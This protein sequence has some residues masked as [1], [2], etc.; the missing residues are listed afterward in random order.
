M[1]FDNPLGLRVA[2][3][4]DLILTMFVARRRRTR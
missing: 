1:I 4:I 3:V 2:Y